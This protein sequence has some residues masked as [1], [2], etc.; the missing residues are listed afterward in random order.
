MLILPERWPDESIYSLLAKI[1]RINGLANLSGA[2]TLVGEERPPS[3]IGCPVD[4]KHFCE[5]TGG[6][7]GSPGDLLRS[8]TPYQLLAH[9]GEV[10]D[11]PISPI[12]NVV[13]K[14]ELGML[15]FG[16]IRSYQWRLC[17][18]CAERDRNTYGI[19]YWH[20]AHQLPYSRYCSEHRL[21]LDR[22][23]MPRVSLLDRLIL[24]A[25]AA[26]L[27]RI[28]IPDSKE[29]NDKALDISILACDA[30]SDSSTPYSQVTICAAFIAGLA[31]NGF[32]N[33]TGGIRMAEYCDEFRLR[34]G[35]LSSQ[36]SAKSRPMVSN[37]RLLLS[38][39]SDDLVPRPFA[40]L[41]LINFLFG[42]WG[43]FK[44]QCKWQDAI[45]PCVNESMNLQVQLSSFEVLLREYRQACLDY[46]ASCPFPMRYEFMRGSYRAFRWLRHNDREW[47]NDELPTKKKL[48]KGQR[49]I[50]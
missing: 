47:L 16:A 9:L 18:E 11:S 25:D 28:M 5:I 1:V 50:F 26:E 45:S 37:P 27:P 15:S 6:V 24:P 38:G 39:I 32:L 20:R 2:G 33:S 36:A 8:S 34:F 22:V 10:G 14:L 19:S 41:V 7:Y 35:G 43:A 46:K 44:E 31:Q 42:S 29:D 21:L 13:R 30:I 17:R 49:K 12:E 3:V 23:A 4:L 40:R 48:I